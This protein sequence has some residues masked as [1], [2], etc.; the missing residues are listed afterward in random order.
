MFRSR[1]FIF[2]ED[3]FDVEKLEC[4]QENFEFSTGSVGNTDNDD[5]KCNNDAPEYGNV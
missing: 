4:A 2:M 1:D 3:K 5:T